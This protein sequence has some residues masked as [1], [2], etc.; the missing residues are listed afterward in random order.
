MTS[1][2]IEGV[3]QK[4]LPNYSQIFEDYIAANQSCLR[5]LYDKLKMHLTKR[6]LLYQGLCLLIASVIFIRFAFWCFDQNAKIPFY[7]CTDVKNHCSDYS[8]NDY[9]LIVN[10]HPE[11]IDGP[12]PICKE[13]NNGCIVSRNR[14]NLC[15][16]AKCGNQ[17][18]SVLHAIGI[19]I[20]GIIGLFCG[21]IGLAMIFDSSNEKL[22]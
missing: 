5:N 9:D 13:C 3:K 1:K 11:S 8:K 15:L 14:Q 2:I 4:D 6:S 21:L 17:K 16:S 19:F 22:N 18:G 20:F 10:C 7:D 12:F